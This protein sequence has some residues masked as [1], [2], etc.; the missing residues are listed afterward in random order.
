MRKSPKF[1]F[2]FLSEISRN[3]HYFIERQNFKD[4]AYDTNR[5]TLKINS[6]AVRSLQ[7]RPTTI[8][9]GQL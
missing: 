3:N 1:Y 2:F 5:N 7:I 6:V 8:N 4:N 9:Q